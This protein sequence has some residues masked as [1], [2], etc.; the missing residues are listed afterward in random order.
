MGP[1]GPCPPSAPQL[2]LLLLFPLCFPRALWGDVVFLPPFIRMFDTSVS[3]ALVGDTEDVSVSLAVWDGELGILPIPDCGLQNNGTSNWS[4]TV[5]PDMMGSEVTVR[6]NGDLQACVSETDFFSDYPCVVESLVVSASRNSFCLAHL[7]IQVEIYPNA[8]F[9]QNASENSTVFVSQKYQPFGP[10]PCNLTAGVCDVRCCCDKECT[11]HLIDMFKE[12]CFTGVIGGEVNPPFDHLCSNP[13]TEEMS[14]W[15][16]FLCVH[17]SLDN[18]PFLGYFF[19][20]LTSHRE[21]YGFNLPEDFEVKDWSD[22][23]YLQDVPL[24]TVEKGVFT[25]PQ[26]SIVGQCIQEAPVGFLQNFD[27]SCVTN[28]A[29]LQERGNI[30]EVKI[31]NGIVG[32]VLLHPGPSFKYVNL[33]E[34]Y[35]FTWQ[36]NQVIALTVKVIWA[37]IHTDQQGILTQRFEVTFV[38]FNATDSPKRS[39]NPG[40]YSG[41]P[42]RALNLE[43]VNNIT[44]LNLWRPVGRGLCTGIETTPVLFGED[45][46]SGCL[47]ELGID[48]NCTQ[49]RAE[50]TDRLNSLVQATHV[51]QKGNSDYHDLNDGWLEII[52]RDVPFYGNH[53]HLRDIK[54][55][56]PDV[57]AV[58]TVHILF[59][60]GGNLEGIPQ[61][62]ILGAEVSF[63][64][65]TWQFQCGMNCENKPNL[66]P[67]SVSVR[68]IKVPPQMPQ[69]LTRRVL[70]FLCRQK[71]DA[72]L[73]RHS[74]PVI[75]QPVGE[76]HQGLGFSLCLTSGSLQTA[77]AALWSGP[78]AMME[79][80]C[81]VTLLLFISVK[82]WYSMISPFVSKYHLLKRLDTSQLVDFIFS[83]SSSWRLSSK[84]GPSLRGGLICPSDGDTPEKL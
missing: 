48:T 18:T 74:D 51:G 16:P 34:H 4:L 11:P 8:S 60:S 83:C 19:H 56:C 49:L 54:G 62:M 13:V 42:V 41:K 38:S 46:I 35:T 40:Y 3:A 58:M 63:S 22:F 79:N 71:L 27:V 23:G 25:V 81:L 10:C 70:Q 20:G 77:V 72:G 66:F 45:A 68:F 36:E 17:S 24:M 47:L 12:Y 61:D 30:S 39:G 65:V 9:A 84:R 82:R 7:L 6:L 76:N 50:V 59:S 31:K 52:R 15:F 14:E 26:M 73:H 80:F 33:E 21:E 75:K 5:T 69:P 37:K 53:L 32:D 78:G 29:A 28:L 43:S 67:I 64:S 57:P 44:T 1:A 55:I 2:W